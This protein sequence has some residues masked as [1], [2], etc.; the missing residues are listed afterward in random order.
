M[1]IWCPWESL[2]ILHHWATLIY[3][4]TGLPKPYLTPKTS[5]PKPKT[6][7][8]NPQTPNSK[9]NRKPQTP[10]PKPQSVSHKP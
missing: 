6:H 10:N 8:P 7:N 2:F 3:M 4:S 1:Y 9:P 5:N